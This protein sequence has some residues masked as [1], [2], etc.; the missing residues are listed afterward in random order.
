MTRKSTT[1]QLSTGGYIDLASPSPN[2]ISIY[3]VASALSNLCR[4]T[5]HVRSFYSVAQH[6][7]LA[8]RTTDDPVFALQ[9]LL[10]DSPEAFLGD[11]STPLK[12]QLPDYR[13]IEKK[14]EKCCQDAFSCGPLSSPEIKQ[15]DRRMLATEVRDLMPD[16][17]PDW[18]ILDD[19]EP[20]N[21][22][23]IP[24]AP[25]AA[26]SHFMARYFKICNAYK[27][28]LKIEMM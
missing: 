9:L 17:K 21:F 13:S 5:G 14:M 10:H 8:S 7:V 15:V 12:A 1:I 27:N 6:S 25:A 28:D 20:Y 23:I 16:K 2:D 3:D 11:V 22:G 26:R 4:F 19:V 18:P 24:W